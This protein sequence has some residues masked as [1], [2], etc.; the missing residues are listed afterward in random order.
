MCDKAIS[1][2]FEF[3]RLFEIGL[4]KNGLSLTFA[5]F[6]S[7]G[8]TNAAFFFNAI[9]SQEKKTG[10]M[11]DESDNSEDDQEASPIPITSSQQLEN[12]TLV[13]KSLWPAITYWLA[14]TTPNGA[15]ANPLVVHR[16]LLDCG[17]G[18]TAYQVNHQVEN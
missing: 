2:K 8:I 17:V 16:A 11:N 1:G 10:S 3:K 13:N 15:P 6:L 7:Q 4:N 9:S 18:V 5:F 12:P 14:L